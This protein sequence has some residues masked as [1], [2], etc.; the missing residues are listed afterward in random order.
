MWHLVAVGHRYNCVIWFIAGR[1]M[2]SD[3]SC[4]PCTM[5]E[6]WRN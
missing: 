5:T 2:K 3:I 6:L 1:R 4:N